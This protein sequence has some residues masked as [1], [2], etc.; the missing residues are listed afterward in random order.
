VIK[1]LFKRIIFNPTPKADQNS[2]LILE[3]KL[4]M[5][6]N[7][8]IKGLRIDIRRA[9]KNRTYVQL[10]NDNVINGTFV[11]ETGEGLISVGN[12]SFLGGGTFICVDGIEI[13]DDVMFSWGCT[14]ADNNAH[15]LISSERA[16]DVKDWKRGLDENKIGHYKDWSKVRTKKIIIKNK[17]W[18]G[19]NSIILKGVT[20]GEGA[21]IGAG[22]VV[23][24][25][26]PNFA[27]VGGNPAKI[28]K[29]TT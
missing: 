21:V 12:N 8:I 2:K 20:I 3:R 29:Y 28:I 27:V 15:S 16:N 10:G 13:G 11:F 1:R 4:I 14:V 23:T 24:V 25:D 19:F 18:I 17:A 6:S 26:V 7:N 9:E 22:S 5:G